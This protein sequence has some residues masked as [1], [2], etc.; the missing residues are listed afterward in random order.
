VLRLPPGATALAESDT[1]RYEVWGW[2]SNV[3]AL[4]VRQGGVTSWKV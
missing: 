2:G 3:L 1:A 4:Q